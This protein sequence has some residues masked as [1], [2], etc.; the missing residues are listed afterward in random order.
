MLYPVQLRSIIYTIH[1]QGKG[2]LWDFWTHFTSIWC[3]S[4]VFIGKNLSIYY[5][6]KS[7]NKQL[8]DSLPFAGEFFKVFTKLKE[9]GHL[10]NDFYLN[11]D[12]EQIDFE[13]IILSSFV[14]FTLN[15]NLDESTMNKMGITISEFKQFLEISRPIFLAVFRLIFSKNFRNFAAQQ[16][17]F[18]KKV[19]KIMDFTLKI[20]KFALFLVIFFSNFF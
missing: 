1:P 10:H 17:F 20:M 9:D 18:S 2:G 6:W 14:S 15:Q 8:V 7:L 3:W 11:Y 12:I 4:C 13:A 19:I 16:R 5:F